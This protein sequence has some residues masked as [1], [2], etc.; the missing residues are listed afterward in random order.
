VQSLLSFVA[1]YLVIHSVDRQTIQNRLYPKVQNPIPITVPI[2]RSCKTS[3][4]VTTVVE[5]TRVLLDVLNP[6]WDTRLLHGVFINPFTYFL[7]VPNLYSYYDDQEYQCSHITL[8][9]F[10]LA[11]H[12]VCWNHPSY[13]YYRN[14]VPRLDHANSY[15]LS[16]VPVQLPSDLHHSNYLGGISGATIHT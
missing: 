16:V 3:I 2:A 15:L 5:I 9:L 6:P 4:R 7:I 10:S 1:L 13:V 8:L 14:T 11:F 12:L